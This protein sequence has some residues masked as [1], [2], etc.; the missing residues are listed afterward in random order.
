MLTSPEM[1]AKAQRRA[2]LGK[3]KSKRENTLPPL[4]LSLVSSFFCHTSFATSTIKQDPH[5]RKREK[6]KGDKKSL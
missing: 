4:Q 1:E 6:E 2:G 3:K 5:I